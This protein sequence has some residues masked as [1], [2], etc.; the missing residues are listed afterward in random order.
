MQFILFKF[1]YIVIEYKVNMLLIFAKKLYCLTYIYI[2]KALHKSVFTLEI[3]TR[4]T[5]FH[6]SLLFVSEV[7]YETACLCGK[8]CGL[9]NSTCQRV[10]FLQQKK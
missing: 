2:Y 7:T 9:H 4:L 8:R 10:G 1:H 3:Y 5:N 6:A